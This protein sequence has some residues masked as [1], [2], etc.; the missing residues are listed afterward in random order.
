MIKN[1]KSLRIERGLTQQQLADL[2]MTSQQSINKYENHNVE[3]DI[4]MLIKLADCFNTSVDYL[5]GH[6]DIRN[7]IEQTEAY[8]LNA[9]EMLLING[10]RALN[11]NQKH[12]I[13]LVINNYI[14]K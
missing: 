5:I 9:E 8:S 4:T 7:K 3:P 1:L 10:F 13:F 12:S 11:R 2:V 14:S 6:T